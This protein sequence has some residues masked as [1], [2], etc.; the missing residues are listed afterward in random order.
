MPS[1]VDVIVNEKEPTRRTTTKSQP[2]AAAFKATSQQSVVRK[3]AYLLIGVTSLLIASLCFYIT[4]N[5]SSLDHRITNASMALP[6]PFS[7]IATALAYENASVAFLSG[8]KARAEF[9][10]HNSAQV[11]RTDAVIFQA[12]HTQYPHKL[13]TT[14]PVTSA[15]LL[16]YATAGHAMAEIMPND[17]EHG[18]GGASWDG[19][20]TWKEYRPPARRLDNEEGGIF[21][22]VIFGKYAYQWKG[23][24]MIVYL[25]EVREAPNNY[26][27]PLQY[28]VGGSDED[29]NELIKEAGA[30]GN[31]L[32]N[33]I[34]V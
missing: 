1:E 21:E 6:N 14:I 8:D 22:K 16:E 4:T 27:P 23:Y 10:H 12:L 15:N 11:V 30:W 31:T 7:R 5:S 28:V 25:V 13:I 29:I 33:Q 3:I 32:H 34:W 18:G 24:D 17:L 19:Q 2:I 20:M 26:S 9:L